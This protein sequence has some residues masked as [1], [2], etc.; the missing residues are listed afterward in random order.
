VSRPTSGTL[1]LYMSLHVNNIIQ[2]FDEWAPTWVAWEKDNVGLQVGD[3]NQRIT[4]VLLALDVT[5][6]IIQEAIAKKAELII[7]HH[8][9]LFRPLSSIT[10]DDAVGKLVVEL[11]RNN[12]S[13]FSAH[14]NLDFSQDGVSFA[15][16][17]KIGLKDVRFLTPLRDS[18]AKIVVFVPEDHVEQVRNA[19]IRAGAGTIGQYTNCS[20]ATKGIGSFRGSLSTNPFLGKPG[21]M[22]FIGENRL[23]IIAP[24]A[25]INNVIA[26]LKAVHPYEEPAYDIYRIENPNSNFGMGAIG[27]LQKPQPLGTFL[28]S[29]Q[30]TL[31]SEMLRF[32]GKTTDKI[33]TVAVCS[34]AGSDLLSDAIAAHA[35]VFITADV[36]YHAFHAASNNIALVDAGHW[37]TEQIVLKPIAERIRSA[38]RK[39]NEPLTVWTTKQITNPIQTI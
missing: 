19:M 18:L 5:W 33:Q 15:L 7:S 6:N 21:N 29:I 10:A 28:K 20:F 23:E 32:T 25:Q 38:V 3:K 35:D 16:A 24:R 17:K 22:E 26:A 30:R 36:R 9:L 1:F 13:L 39:M 14:T 2:L 31:G 4:K 11:A 27:S 37:E 8:P 12:I 34:G